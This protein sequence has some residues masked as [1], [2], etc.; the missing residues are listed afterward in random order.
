LR[1]ATVTNSD[2][3]LI[4]KHILVGLTYLDHA[5]NVARQIQLHGFITYVS[6]STIRFE[7]ADGDGEFAIPRD[8]S[9]SPADREAV[10]SLRSTGESVTEVDF[11]DSW[12]IHPKPEGE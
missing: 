6:D 5:G 10:Y 1:G 2:D 8:G 7:R 12:T 4:G 3:S 9:L 11:V